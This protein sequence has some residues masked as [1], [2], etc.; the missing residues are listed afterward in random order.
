MDGFGSILNMISPPSPH[1]DY[2]ENPNSPLDYTG[3][4]LD[5]ILDNKPSVKQP[6]N[7]R[8][9]NLRQILVQYRDCIA[10]YTYMYMYR[11]AM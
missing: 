1:L 11:F 7:C 9:L 4:P 3:N 6:A 5:A 10:I 8:L 2:T